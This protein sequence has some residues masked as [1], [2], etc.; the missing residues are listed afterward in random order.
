MC[1]GQRVVSILP[2]EVKLRTFNRA[3][4]QEICKCHSVPIS[5]RRSC[6]RRG[7]PRAVPILQPPPSPCQRRRTAAFA[8]RG[9]RRAARGPEP[10]G[11][12]AS[13]RPDFY[14]RSRIDPFR[15]SVALSGEI[16]VYGRRLGADPRPRGRHWAPIPALRAAAATVQHLDWLIA[17]PSPAAALYGAGVLVQAPQPARYAVHKLI[18]AQRREAG[19]AKRQKDLDQA[20][21]LIEALRQTEPFAVED[22][23]DDARKRGRRDWRDRIDRSLRQIGLNELVDSRAENSPR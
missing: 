3:A 10:R 6:A 23:L 4:F 11:N 12:S 9:F 20:R 16:R 13:G 15:V 7:R 1:I 19:S 21:A 14:W 17:G 22:A 5:S 18:V 8:P 2:Y